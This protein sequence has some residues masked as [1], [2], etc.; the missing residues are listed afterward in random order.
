M[1]ATPLI[2]FCTLWFGVATGVVSLVIFRR[3]LGLTA[4]LD[5]TVPTVQGAP[6]VAANARE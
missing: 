5:D 3:C 4:A 2:R 6:I 1:V